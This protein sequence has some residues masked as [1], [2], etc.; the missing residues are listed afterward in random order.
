MKRTRCGR[1]CIFWLSGGGAVHAK[2]PTDLERT[3]A[4]IGREETHSF[5]SIFYLRRKW[6]LG[7][8]GY[9]Q[10]L[11]NDR[12]KVHSIE[13]C[14]TFSFGSLRLPSVI[15]FWLW[16]PRVPKR[17]TDFWNR[18][19]FHLNNFFPRGS[20]GWKKNSVWAQCQG[21]S[22]PLNKNWK[23]KQPRF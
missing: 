11:S 8:A 17:Y 13:F 2:L 20:F 1:T 18:I 6:G 9:T 15:L 14:Q 19:G 3:T 23:N 10:H 4:C 21:H 7:M 5:G 16:K 12:G 22:L